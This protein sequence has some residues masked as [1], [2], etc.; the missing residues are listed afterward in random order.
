MASAAPAA[1]LEVFQA[2]IAVERSYVR[3]VARAVLFTI[4]FHRVLGTLSK[5]STL[6]VCG[7]TFPAPAE[8]EL[9]ELVERKVDLLVK[10]LSGEGRT[11][12][13]FVTLYPTPLPA[14]PPSQRPL[15]RPSTPSATSRSASPS[16]A[17]AP[18]SSRSP[19]RP[20]SASAARR[21]A[22]SIAQAAP[23]AVTSALGWFS[24]SARAALGGGEA[25][26]EAEGAK[27]EAQEEEVRMVEALK[28]QG[29]TAWEG[30][31]VEFE[32]LSDAVGMG[33]TRSRRSTA[34]EERLRT[35][36]NDF[37]LRSLHFTM[38]K[39][40]HIP[41]ITTAELMPYGVVVLVDPVTPPFAV[42][43][44]VIADL[45]TFPALHRALVSPAGEKTVEALRAASVG[46]RW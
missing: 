16:T 30:W 18:S 1:K 9:E 17:D 27:D 33:G 46:A 40:S 42:P 25:A 29:R 44:P 41:P 11:A 14:L 7:V 13:L 37:L 19:T 20:A 35:Q 23:A 45:K 31:C 15:Q 22:S 24:A 6:E 43:K 28:A 36:L 34:T 5:P 10:A 32:A 8:R 2:S 39:T 21:H 38:T 26:G 3:E 12:K 4:L